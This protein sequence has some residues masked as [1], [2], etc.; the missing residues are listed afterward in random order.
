ML[1]TDRRPLHTHPNHSCI[2]QLDPQTHVP[3][4][5]LW[6]LKMSSPRPHHLWLLM[7]CLWHF[8]SLPRHTQTQHKQK[9]NWPAQPLSPNFTFLNLYLS[10]CEPEPLLSYINWRTFPPCFSRRPALYH[11]KRQTQSPLT[12]GSTIST[13]FCKTQGFFLN[14]THYGHLFKLELLQLFQTKDPRKHHQS[15]TAG[16]P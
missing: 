5:I 13:K 7:A 8:H 12:S 9:Q 15:L 4:H 2:C 6:F 11:T 3:P 10:H 14:Y 1:T 16:L